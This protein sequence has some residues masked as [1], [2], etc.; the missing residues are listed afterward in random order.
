MWARI[1]E[2][3]LAGCLALIP[4]FATERSPELWLVGLGAAAVIAL[5]SGL[6]FTK[7]FRRIHLVLLPFSL[8]LY[9][10]GRLTHEGITTIALLLLMFALIP[11]QASLPPP[12]WRSSRVRGR[13]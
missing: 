13:A 7:R 9:G 3:I 2:L 8:I 10:I 6:S 11:S 5:F 12:A 4:V 1:C